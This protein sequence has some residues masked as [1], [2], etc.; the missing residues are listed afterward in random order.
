[1]FWCVIFLSSKI[2]SLDPVADKESEPP[3][4]PELNPPDHRV[5]GA[6]LELDPNLGTVPNCDT[7]ASSAGHRGSAAE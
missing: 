3:N 6:M 4:S 5:P 7:G 2:I 1:L